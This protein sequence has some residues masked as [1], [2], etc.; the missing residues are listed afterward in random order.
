MS[1]DE[2]SRAQIAA[3][4]PEGST[5]LVANAGSG[6][7]RVLTNRVAWLLLQGARP[8]RILCLT[9]TKAAASEMQNRLFE[10]LGAWAMLSDGDLAGALAEMG[11]R[12]Q[13]RGPGQ[14]ARARTLFAQAIEAPG[15]LK[16]QTIH[17]YA[18]YILRRF[19]LEA[20]VTPNFVEIEDRQQALLAAEVLDAMA[21]GPDA[22]LVAGVAAYLSGSD[23]DAFL[24]AILSERRGLAQPR[25]WGEIAGYFEIAPELKGEEIVAR[26]FLGGEGE[27]ARRLEPHL[28]GERSPQAK[29]KTL[30]PR[31]PWEAPELH[32]FA[33]L[34]DAVLTGS[35]AK[36]P[37]VPKP[38]ISTN[39]AVID[40]LG[41]DIEAWLAFLERVAEGRAARRGLIAAERAYA[42]SRFAARWLSLYA[43]A[44]ALR[45]WLDF[46]DLIEKTEGLLRDA[47]LAPWVLYRLDGG[48]DHLLVDEAQDTS[49]AQWRIIAALAEEFAAGQGARDEVERSLFVVGD[50]KQSIYSFQGAD[51]DGFDRMGDF[52]EARL[53]GAARPLARHQL[54]WS[55]RSAPVILELVDHIA[56]GDGA[57]GLGGG[58]A[59]RAFRGRMPGRVDIWPVIEKAE[60]K[61]DKGPWYAP[62]DMP[63][64]ADPR[65]RM[66]ARVADWLAATLREPPLIDTPQGRRPVGPGDILILVRK[67]DPV[68]FP[69]LIREIKA[70]GLP[71]LGADKFTVTDHVA[72]KDLQA[73]LHV[74]NTRED[75]LALATVLRSPLVGWDEAQLFDLAHGRPGYLY[76]A[77][78][79]RGGPEAETLRDLSGKAEFLR[80]FELLQRALVQHG[81]RRRLVGRLGQEAEDAIDALLSQAQLYERQAVPN[82]TGFLDWLELG[83]LKLKRDPSGQEGMIR[84]MTVHGAK[85]LE[86]PVVIVPDA[87]INQSMAD[88]VRLI[89]AEAAPVAWLA[90]GDDYP[91]AQRAEVAARKLKDEEE[92]N[93]LLYVALTRAANWLIVGAA[94]RIKADKKP[95]EVACWYGKV[96][97]AARELGAEPLEIEGEMGLRL[98]A[99]DWSVAAEAG[100]GEAPEAGPVPALPDWAGRKVSG[101]RATATV[102]RPSDLGGAKALGGEAEGLDETAALRRGRHIHLLLEHLPALPRDQWEDAVSDILSLDGRHD[103]SGDALTELAAEA[104]AVLGAPELA[105]IFAPDSL[106]EV[107]LSAGSDTLGAQLE[108]QIDR[109]LVRD[110]RV[111]AVDFKSNAVVPEGPGEVPEGLLRQMGAYA[112]MLAAIYPER[113]IETALL[114][115]REARLMH[116]DGDLTR[117][118]LGRAGSGSGDL[119]ETLTQP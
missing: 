13:D 94:G 56:R 23:M 104:A 63:N 2:A 54:L 8:E 92:A 93:R 65:M 110:D 91:T 116:L 50:R 30:V 26:T 25:D 107:A 64:A 53:A 37:D 71:I 113:R 96:E 28:K 70:R 1:L 101:A 12:E 68:M 100:A 57:E 43:E 90:P 46:D 49:P 35:K 75:D 112:E 15:G 44:K 109:L 106:A 95:P 10:R 117:A 78:M 11:V 29:L 58:V 42:L 69:R 72:V 114:W 88:K 115:T 84:I 32:D 47:S 33:A 118:A 6:K 105:E 7:T 39:K 82:L 81:M 80:P 74:L 111:L 98:Q 73:L 34:E 18:A 61:Q 55:F 87:H 3:A 60:D 102:L 83:E 4:D 38:I 45:G 5:W 21:E 119:H 97:K 16:I 36:T 19:P 14:L 41:P 86:A 59:H 22:P 77:L 48:I 31:F 27:I 62:V 76:N 17:A 85:G 66:A 40:A 51:P 89:G 108:G 9:Y 79:E 20:G 52:F 67:R 24:K 103:L 99:G